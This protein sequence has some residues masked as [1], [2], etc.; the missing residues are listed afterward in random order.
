LP[1]LK[2]T[3][4]SYLLQTWS[5][6]SETESRLLSSLVLWYRHRSRCSSTA[7]RSRFCKRLGGSI[8]DGGR[9]ALEE[10][11]KKN[12]KG[13]KTKLQLRTYNDLSVFRRDF[14]K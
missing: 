6:S 5:I 12:K 9:Y 10:L 7:W 11:R 13:I 8:T 1:I 4:D 2:V 3:R 14:S